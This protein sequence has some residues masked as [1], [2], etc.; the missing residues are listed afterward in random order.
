MSED[1]KEFAK[2]LSDYDELDLEYYRVSQNLPSEPQYQQTGVYRPKDMADFKRQMANY[3]ENKELQK[4]VEQ[5][6]KEASKAL[7]EWIPQFVTS[8]LSVGATIIAPVPGGFI[9]LRKKTGKYTLIKGASEQDIMQ[10]L[11]SHTAQ[12]EN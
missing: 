12:Y 6:R 7:D 1:E 4:Q 3:L 11:P 5:K 10:K 2:L 9:G 8:R